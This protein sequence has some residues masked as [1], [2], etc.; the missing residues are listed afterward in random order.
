MKLL[1]TLESFLAVTKWFA[2]DTLTL[3]DLGFLVTVGTIKVISF[4]INFN[5]FL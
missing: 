1:E 2:G 5:Q 4:V 3:A